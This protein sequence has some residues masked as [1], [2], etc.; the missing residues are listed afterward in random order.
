MSLFDYKIY[1]TFKHTGFCSRDENRTFYCISREENLGLLFKKGK[2][3]GEKGK[4]I[5]TILKTQGAPF[6]FFL[7]RVETGWQ[8]KVEVEKMYDSK[9]KSCSLNL[10]SS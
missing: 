2:L 8:G 7:G 6:K 5:K 10:M 3:Q 4:L 9:R 1:Y